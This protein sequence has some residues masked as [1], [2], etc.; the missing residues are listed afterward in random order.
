MLW[1][2]QVEEVTD[3]FTDRAFVQGYNVL[4]NTMGNEPN[5]FLRSLMKRAREKPHGYKVVILGSY[6]PW[7]ECKRRGK[8]RG[9][10]HGRHVAEGFA[11]REYE[12]M[13]PKG[14]CDRTHYDKFEEELLPGDE[15]YLFDNSTHNQAPQLFAH[16]VAKLRIDKLDMGKLEKEKQKDDEKAKEKQTARESSRNSIKKILREL[17]I[18]RN[19]RNDLCVLIE[20]LNEQEGN[21]EE[22]AAKERELELLENKLLGFM[23]KVG[24]DFE[25]YV[26]AQK[27]MVP[28]IERLEDRNPKMRRLAEIALSKIKML[29]P[30]LLD[31]TEYEELVKEMKSLPKRIFNNLADGEGYAP[32]LRD[33]ARR[34][35]LCR[36]PAISLA[37]IQDLGDGTW[38]LTRM[39]HN[40]REKA[41]TAVE[42]F[43]RLA[44]LRKLLGTDER[45]IAELDR[46]YRKLGTQLA[47]PPK[48][49]HSRY[50][51]FPTL[52][53]M[54]SDRIRIIDTLVGTPV[55][56]LPLNILVGQACALFVL[57]VD[58][59]TLM[60]LIVFT[61]KVSLEIAH[62][63]HDGVSLVEE[64]VSANI[65]HLSILYICSIY[66]LGREFFSIWAFR[67]LGE[68]TRMKD[69][70]PISMWT[71]LG[72][73]WKLLNIAN[74]LS[75]MAFCFVS[76]QQG[77]AYWQIP[78]ASWTTGMLWLRLLGYMRVLNINF[79]TYITCLG[80]ILYDI[81]YFL[82]I[83]VIVM[84]LFGSMIF[85]W[86]ID[87][88]YIDIA[89]E[90][91]W[92]VEGELEISH[93]SHDSSNFDMNTFR[94]VFETLLTMF[95]CVLGESHRYWFHSAMDISI[96]VLYEIIVVILMLNVLIAV[97]GDSYEY[98]I[99]RARTTFVETRVELVVELETL[100]LTDPYTRINKWVREVQKKMAPRSRASVRSE[101]PNTLAKKEKARRVGGQLLTRRLDRGGDIDDVDLED[102]EISQL[103]KVGYGLLG[104]LQRTIF[105]EE[106]TV[107][108][109]DINTADSWLGRALDM[110]RRTQKIVSM[111]ELN[112]EDTLVSKV[113]R[114][115]RDI[116]E[117]KQLHGIQ[118][119]LEA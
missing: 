13:F 79:A 66:V 71:H 6:A 75:S 105:M 61:F 88:N 92:N 28:V 99:I 16:D 115:H 29:Q 100:G 30:N 42:F 15:R 2:Y 27:A 106:D 97:V 91:S 118:A 55:L 119:P 96:Y 57:V 21:D 20:K 86:N 93:H 12:K 31:D 53:A 47:I 17:D 108:L 63:R 102:D 67:R 32:K 83:M 11:K 65:F 34:M 44:D 73:K 70:Q 68:D 23:Q 26:V 109:R 25:P 104:M 1:G 85:I 110:E 50:T 69:H 33:Y 37:L 72:N 95:R 80:Q 76:S 81:T 22:I 111:A 7:D 51:L 94:T 24:N 35:Q 62:N 74:A 3:A 40:K 8:S 14:E 64:A 98:S 9:E 87:A 59:I 60:L 117:L 43:E 19:D 77:F 58:F 56:N 38:L 107:S 5:R 84:L 49:W 82:I 10:E 103:S 48:E 39:C 112:L 116:M 78:L 113:E 41:E 46:F 54:K 101:T 114:M 89:W 52:Y 18:F 4:Y 45:R 90:P 36:M